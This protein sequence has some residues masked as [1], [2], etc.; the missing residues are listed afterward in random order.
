MPVEARCLWKSEVGV[1]YPGIGITDSYEPPG[2]CWESKPRLCAK[3]ASALN[4]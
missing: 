4:L 2:R 3:V 1:R